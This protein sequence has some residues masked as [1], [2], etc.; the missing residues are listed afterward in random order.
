ME[1]KELNINFFFCSKDVMQRKHALLKTKGLKYFVW[2][3]E[4]C[5]PKINVGKTDTEQCIWIVEAEF[6]INYTKHYEQKE[7]VLKIL[8]WQKISWVLWNAN[9]LSDSM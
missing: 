7:F 2:E 4:K 3:L 6:Q 1:E 9:E 5:I 8:L